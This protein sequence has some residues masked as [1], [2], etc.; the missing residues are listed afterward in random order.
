MKKLLALILSALMIV[1]F[2]A[3]CT[4]SEDGGGTGGGGGGGGGGGDDA[5]STPVV[6]V[7]SSKEDLRVWSFTDEIPN[8]IARYVEMNPDSQVAN[9]NIIPTILTDWSGDFENGIK[10]ALEAGGSNA[11][12]LYM[13]EQ[14]FVLTFTQGDYSS[15]AMPYNEMI[16]GLDTKISDAQL[17]QYAVKAGT[18]GDGNVVGLRFQ[19]TG[20]CLIY[21]R[22]I[23]EAAFGASDPATVAA[24]TGPGWDKFKAAAQKVSDAGYA[25]VYGDEDLWQ[26]ARDGAT[27]PWIN[28]AG[29]LVIDP[30]REAYFDLAKEFY[31]NKWVVGSGAWDDGWFAGMAG[32]TTPPVFSYIGPAWLINYQINDNALSGE[33]FGDWAVTTSPLPWAWGGTWLMANKD[34]TGDKKAAVAEIIEWITLDTS[35]DGFQYHFANGTLYEGSALFPDEAKKVTDGTNAKDAVASKVVMEKSVG[36]LAVVDG[37]DIFEYFLPAGQNASSDHW[38][39]WDRALNGE[40]QNQCRMYYNG[41]KSKEE[42]I[43]DFKVWANE[44]LGVAID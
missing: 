6:P 15:F 35:N 18:R 37:Q 36:T 25:M 29:K 11:P 16:D 5:G 14:A 30:A 41:E 31:D 28:S 44:T 2:A 34:L 7:D 3:G 9:F 17:A 10:P 21:R 26:V 19:E 13:A 20:S 38:H 32:T 27:Q 12:D 4:S 1:G 39:E 22:S 33:S 43:Q 8:A 42:A 24:E 40:F 23:A